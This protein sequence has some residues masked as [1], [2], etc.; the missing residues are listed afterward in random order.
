MPHTITTAKVCKTRQA[1][2]GKA[3]K[4][5][6]WKCSNRSKIRSGRLRE[7]ERE[8]KIEVGCRLTGEWV[9][10]LDSMS[11]RERERRE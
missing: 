9:G 4:Q 6:S 3:G 11:E 2:Q 7:R 5:L 1:R 10:Q 8:R